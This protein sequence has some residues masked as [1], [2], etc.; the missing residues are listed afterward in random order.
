MFHTS[1]TRT[2]KFY[3]AIQV[4]HQPAGDI[5]ELH[6]ASLLASYSYS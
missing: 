2:N 1:D 6:L 3:A 4:E 5:M